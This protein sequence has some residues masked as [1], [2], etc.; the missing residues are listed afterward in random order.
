MVIRRMSL[1]DKDMQR[2]ELPEQA[3]ILSIRDCSSLWLYYVVIDDDSSKRGRWI[4]RCAEQGALEQKHTRE[5]IC[6]TE[7]VLNMKSKKTG[8]AFTRVSHWFECLTKGVSDAG[9]V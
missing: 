1:K 3:E 4:E 2:I 6:T 9:K 7:N 8:D 5:Y